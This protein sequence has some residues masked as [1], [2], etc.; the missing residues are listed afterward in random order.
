MNQHNAQ[1]LGMQVRIIGKNAVGE[2]IE[3]PCEFY[4][5]ETSSRDY[6]REKLLAM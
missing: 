6:K 2:V 3:S 1:L 4:A 5:G